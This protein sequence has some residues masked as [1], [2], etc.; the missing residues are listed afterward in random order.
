M[1]PNQPYPQYPSQPG[2]PPQNVGMPMSMQKKHHSWGLIISLICFIFISIGALGFGIWAYA[3]MADY[4]GNSDQKA[5]AAVE[6]AVQK[7]ASRK[8]AEFVEKEKEPLTKYLGPS[9]FGTLDISYPKTWSA[10]VTEVTQSGT[11][12]DGYFHPNFVP[13]IQGGTAFALR[14]VVTAQSY[15]QELGQFDGQV[16]AGK[17]K[18]SPFRAKNVDSVTGSRVDGE[19]VF[20]KQGSIILL[21]LRD[22]TLK[23]YTESQQYMNDFNN[24]ILPNLK[25]VP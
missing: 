8:D 24:I 11:P 6:I 10:F 17:V 25:F 2:M 16:T 9:A 22:K 20:G 15:E 5:A 21:P 4:K 19:I 3:G 13:G 7:E 18:V 23:I 14:V 1:P 12:V